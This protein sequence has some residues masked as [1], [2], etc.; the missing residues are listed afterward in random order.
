VIKKFG[1]IKESGGSSPRQGPLAYGGGVQATVHRFDA[2]T[3]SG[4]VVTDS[5][6]LLPF[7][8]DAFA[9]S[10]LRHV[11]TGQRLTVVVEGDDADARVVALSLGTVGRP[12]ARPSRP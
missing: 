8:A 4:T 11:R 5:G 9:G 1:G 10:H 6:I 12:P 7:D 2:A 3:R